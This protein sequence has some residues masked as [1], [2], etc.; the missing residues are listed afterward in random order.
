MEL[1]KVDKISPACIFSLKSYH[2][3]SKSFLICFDLQ[4]QVAHNSKFYFIS[5]FQTALFQPV[6][7]NSNKN[8][9]FT[10]NST[11]QK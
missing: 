4:T 6:P 11:L 9:P 1:D 3:F 2:E 7:P 8:T 10:H 5:L